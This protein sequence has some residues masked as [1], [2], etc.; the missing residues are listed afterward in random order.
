MSASKFVSDTYLAKLCYFYDNRFDNSRAKL[1][2]FNFVEYRYIHNNA[3]FSVWNTKRSVTNFPRFFT[4]NCT[5]Q[6]LFRIKLSLT[7]G[8]NFPNKDIVWPNFGA[9]YNNTVFSQVSK[10]HLG[11]I[12]NITSKLFRAKLCFN[13]ISLIFFDMNGSKKVVFHQSIRNQNRVFKTISFKVCISNS[14]VLPKSKITTVTCW[15]ICEKVAGL[16]FCT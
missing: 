8:S 4:K 11:D 9:Y 6:A 1:I 12:R 2:T 3:T 16:H 7:F 5:K 13:H 10:L 14:Q 15:S